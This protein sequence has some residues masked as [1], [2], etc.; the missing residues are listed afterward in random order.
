MGVSV[1]RNR[2]NN[3]LRNRITETDTDRNDLR[4]AKKIT[5]SNNRNRIYGNVRKRK[6]AQIQ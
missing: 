3:R 5:V 2:I 1:S 4:R 6:T